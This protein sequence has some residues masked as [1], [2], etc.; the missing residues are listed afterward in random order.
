MFS[1]F[2][3][4]LH[5]RLGVRVRGLRYF[6]P[7]VAV[8]PAPSLLLL[9]LLHMLLLRLLLLLL[10]LEVLLVV[11]E[12]RSRRGEPLAERDLLLEHPLYVWVTRRLLQLLAVHPVPECIHHPDLKVHEGERERIRVP[13]V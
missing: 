12:L 4:V 11:H 13:R 6:D 1:L 7:R 9:L 5:S 8:A 3:S 10:L 2:L